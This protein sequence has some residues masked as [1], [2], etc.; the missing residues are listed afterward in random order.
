MP[1]KNAAPLQLWLFAQPSTKQLY[2]PTIVACPRLNP[3]PP[4]DPKRH[5]GIE[6]DPAQSD[7]HTSFTYLLLR[8]LQS[9]VKAD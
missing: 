3:V 9:R 7:Y 8:L 6:S 1:S 4:N 2:C 5:C